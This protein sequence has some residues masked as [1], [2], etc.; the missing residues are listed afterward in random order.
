MSKIASNTGDNT[1]DE[2]NINISFYFVY[3][4]IFH[5]FAAFIYRRPKLY[6]GVKVLLFSILL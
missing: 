2:V 4:L 5:M 6:F 3:Y 1:Q